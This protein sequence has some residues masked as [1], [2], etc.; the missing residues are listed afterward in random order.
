MDE[1]YL[2]IEFIRQINRFTPNHKA[3]VIDIKADSVLATSHFTNLYA[4]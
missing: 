3:Q 4:K 1:N 2:I